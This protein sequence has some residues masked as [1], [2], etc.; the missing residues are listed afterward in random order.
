MWDILRNIL[1]AVISLIGLYAINKSVQKKKGVEDELGKI[2]FSLTPFYKWLGYLLIYVNIL[3]WIS[4]SSNSEEDKIALIFLTLFF[5]GSG[6]LIIT[7]FY[8]IWFAMDEKELSYRGIWRGPIILNWDEIKT[9]KFNVWSSS[10]VF[11]NKEGKKVLAHAHLQGIS[12]ILEIIEKKKGL[13]KK[14]IKFPY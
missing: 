13:T 6:I 11:K 4:T 1:F 14:D 10:L 9:I 5:G 2:R 8:R 3:V 7:L 12:Q